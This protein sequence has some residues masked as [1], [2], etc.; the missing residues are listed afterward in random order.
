M[1]IWA[2]LR[3]GKKETTLWYDL[4]S[5][6][7]EGCI[8]DMTSEGNHRKIA[9]LSDFDGTICPTQMMTY[10]YEKF[11]DVG[12][13]YEDLWERGKISTQQEIE[14]TF[15]TV[16]ATKEQMEASLKSVSLDPGFPKF[17]ELCHQKE[18]EFAIVSD[19]LR[20]YIKFLLAKHG[21]FDIPI[22]ANDISFEG[23]TFTFKFPWYHSSCP[24]RAVC[25]SE[26]IR[27]Y[28]SEG[29]KVIYIGDGVSDYEAAGVADE[30]YATGKLADYCEKIGYPAKEFHN[31]EEL[32]LA[33]R[34]HR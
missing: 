18:Y 3:E 27:R 13:K 15:A 33:W 9:F 8:P 24:M 6:I 20:W 17:L 19:G 31:F 30:I 26:V 1:I 32:Y 21:I 2:D 28:K 5:T 22:Y 12:S 34:E 7:K 14:M 23:S 11:A 25:K 16:H 4:P 10:L 29:A